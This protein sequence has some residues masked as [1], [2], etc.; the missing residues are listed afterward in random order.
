[1]THIRRYVFLRNG[2]L[3]APVWGRPTAFSAG[4]ASSGT[5]NAA[6]S[7]AV[8]LVLCKF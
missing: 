7:S 8:D 6:T 1:M 4:G 3:Y 2:D 5:R